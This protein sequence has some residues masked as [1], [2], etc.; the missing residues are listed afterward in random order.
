[1]PESPIGYRYWFDD[2]L[3]ITKVPYHYLTPIKQQG[4]E[5]NYPKPR[6]RHLD[7]FHYFSNNTLYSKDYFSYYDN[8]ISGIDKRAS[9]VV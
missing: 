1:M 2:N 6:L 8:R 4:Y 3:E 5:K 9:K 7:Q